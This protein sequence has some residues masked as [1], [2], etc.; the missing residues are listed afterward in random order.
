MTHDIQMVHEVINRWSD[1]EL[2][3]D[4]DAFS[5]LLTDDFHGIGPVGFVL[6][7]G[8]WAQRHRGEA[9]NEAF[10][11][12]ERRVRIHGDTAIVVAIQR[13][14]TI[15]HG[16]DSSGDFRVGLVLVRDGGA[17]RIAN[18]Q[19]SG[20]LIAPGETAPFIAAREKGTP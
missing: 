14:R 4:A 6:D 16:H 3:G 5:A 13:Q 10:E 9:V 19:L 1:A 12:L 7:G 8:R 20:P 18:I 11:I 15:A 17:W 2:T